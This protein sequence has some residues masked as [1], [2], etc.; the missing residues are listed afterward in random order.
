M[1]LRYINTILLLTLFS[2][3]IFTQDVH[4]SQF[5]YIPLQINP[6]S[7]GDFNGCYRIHSTYRNQWNSVSSPFLTYLISF[8][9]PLKTKNFSENKYGI[10][11][12]LMNDQYSSKGFN[13]F[14]GA[15]SFSAHRFLDAEK[16]HKLSASL[17]LGIVQK[18]INISEFSFFNQYDKDQGFDLGLPSGESFESSSIF[19]PDFSIGSIYHYNSPNMIKFK[20]GLSIHHLFRPKESFLSGGSHRIHRRYNL[21]AIMAYPWL[22]K[23]TLRPSLLFMTQ[24]YTQSLIIGSDLK[25]DLS[26]SNSSRIAHIGLWYR[27]SDAIIVAAGMNFKGHQF[28]VAY[29][30]N[31]SGL[32]VVSN[33]QGGVEL[34]YKHILKCFP[35]IPL[36]FTIPCI[37]L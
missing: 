8:D 17:Q 10:G 4:F 37:R 29:D 30:I 25:Y 13:H 35:K 24:S 22:E 3:F 31:V 1:I 9:E 6:A 32:S 5:N 21:N 36:D 11:V 7:A 14:L 16:D 34:T 18:S 33:N 12:I 19:Y 26:N 15:V 20:L 23:I 2:G 27:T 28:S